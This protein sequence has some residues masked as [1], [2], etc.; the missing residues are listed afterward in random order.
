MYLVS[1]GVGVLTRPNEQA[2]HL[3]RST[4]YSTPIPKL[5]SR[6]AESKYGEIDRPLTNLLPATG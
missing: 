4:L 1:C 3:T 6:E 5:L 2:A